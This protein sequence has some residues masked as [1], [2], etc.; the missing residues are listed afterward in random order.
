MPIASGDARRNGRAT[1][2]TSRTLPRML[3]RTLIT[4]AIGFSLLTTGCD[5]QDF[6]GAYDNPQALASELGCTFNPD[7]PPLPRTRAS[8]TCDLRNAPIQILFFDGQ[9]ERSA[10]RSEQL[11]EHERVVEGANFLLVAESA[12]QVNWAREHLVPGTFK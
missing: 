1:S 7:Q 4:L 12:A 2:L 10:Y 3:R 8:G 6:T 11:A 5:G 9:D